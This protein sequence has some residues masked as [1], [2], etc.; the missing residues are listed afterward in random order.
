M[1][2]LDIERPGELVSYLR[3]TGRIGAEETPRVAALRELREEAGVVGEIVDSV[4]TQH[5]AKA[6]EDV[7]VEYFLVREVSSTR[8]EE[9]RT[10]RWEDF[11]TA[12]ELLTFADA[13]NALQQAAAAL[14]EPE[15]TG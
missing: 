1:A 14:R 4:T 8:A 6:E 13:K 15:P 11:H 9:E 10:L 2:E 5:F 3:E 7:V 12:F